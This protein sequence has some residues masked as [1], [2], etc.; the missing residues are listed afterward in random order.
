[1]KDYLENCV[2]KYTGLC[3]QD[4]RV[5][6]AASDTTG[7]AASALLLTTVSGRRPSRALSTI[8]APP[9]PQVL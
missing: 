6:A 8:Y 7:S 2:I 3:L 9:C 1:M 5:S 4:L